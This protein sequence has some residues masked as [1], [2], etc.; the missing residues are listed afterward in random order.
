MLT[1][2]SVLIMVGCSIAGTVLRSLSGGMSQEVMLCWAACVPVVVMGAPIGSLVLT[3]QRTEPLRR[4]F[5]VLAL[6]QFVTFAILKIRG[7]LLAWMFTLSALM[8]IA[9]YLFCHYV[10]VVRAGRRRCSSMLPIAL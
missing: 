4:C 6:V 10:F 2:S 1:A 5:Y 8:F 3:P 7:N 9:L